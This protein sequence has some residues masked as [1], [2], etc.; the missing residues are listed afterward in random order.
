MSLVHWNKSVLSFHLK[1]IIEDHN[2]GNS[3]ALVGLGAILLGT[4]VLP[5]AAKLGRPIL[6]SVIKSGISLYEQSKSEIDTVV[7]SKQQATSPTLTSS[8]TKIKVP[9][10]TTS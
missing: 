3:T 1:E 6:K 8:D 10:E 7:T 4:T 9:V 5:A 2:A